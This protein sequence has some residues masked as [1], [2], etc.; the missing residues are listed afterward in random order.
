[1]CFNP[2]ITRNIQL[3]RS[4]GWEIVEGI[5]II[6]HQV[7]EQY[8]LWVGEDVSDKIPV[9]EAWKVLRKAADES[10]AINF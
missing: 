10:K 1:M 5:C 6:G 8:R 7:Q 2:R 4:H 9:D 3:A